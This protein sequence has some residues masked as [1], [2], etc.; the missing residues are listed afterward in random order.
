L[1]GREPFSGAT[2]AN[3]N[4]AFDAEL[5]IDDDETGVIV[6][7]VAAGSIAEEIGLEPGDIV[8]AVNDQ[9]IDSVATLQREVRSPEPWHVTIRRQGQ[10]LA[11]AVG[12]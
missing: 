12:G 5:G 1:G 7:Q 2:V 6:R 8:L 11:F 3:L 9:E 10:R 4:P